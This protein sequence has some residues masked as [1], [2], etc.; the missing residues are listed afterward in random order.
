MP[1]PSPERPDP[2]PAEKARGGEIILRKRW[3]RIVFIGALALAVVIGFVL[4]LWNR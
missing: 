3:Q 2:Y 1:D 4:S